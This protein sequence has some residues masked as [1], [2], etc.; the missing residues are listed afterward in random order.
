MT[1]EKLSKFYILIAKV[2]KFRFESG[3][4][5]G[6]HDKNYALRLK[7]DINITRNHEAGEMSR[8]ILINR[9]STLL[10]VRSITRSRVPGR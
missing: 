10:V 6:K 7:N 5:G 2:V 9:H 1:Q 4:F 8:S 3:K